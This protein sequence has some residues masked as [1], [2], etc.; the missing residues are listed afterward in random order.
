MEM[1][2]KNLK[3]Y[4][5]KSLLMKN[6]KSYKY[7]LS[8]IFIFSS[9]YGVYAYSPIQN[10]SWL[11]KCY[12]KID[13]TTYNWTVYSKWWNEISCNWSLNFSSLPNSIWD[14][15]DW[16]YYL[17]LKWD[18]STILWEDKSYSDWTN[19]SKSN[20][21]WIKE[22]WPYKID[23]KAPTCTLKELKFISWKSNNQYY[24]NWKL[25]YKGN[26]WA[27]EFDL[28]IESND[29]WS[30]SNTSEIKEIKFPTILWATPSIQSFTNSWKVI[31][32]WKYSWS[33][34]QNDTFDILNNNVDVCFDN[35]WNNSKLSKDSSTKITFENWNSIVWINNLKLTP[36]N[37]VPNIAW[38]NYDLMI[39]WIK[40]KSWNDWNWS[41]ISVYDWDSLNSKYFSA[42]H[43]RELIIP[44]FQDNLSWLKSF[45]VNIEKAYDKNS[46]S[47]YI[48]SLS[49]SDS[50]V[51]N[52]SNLSLIHDF[53][54]IDLDINSNWYRPYSWDIQTLNLSWNPVETDKIC[55]MVWNC[56]STPTPDFKLVAN[57]PILAQ[58]LNLTS[59]YNWIKHNLN[60]IYEW[61]ISNLYDDYN[62]VVNFEDIYWNAIVAVSWVKKIKLNSSF[63]NT[64]WCNQYNSPNDWDC[65]DFAFRNQIDNNLIT[66]Y[67]HDVAAEKHI[68]NYIIDQY[69]QFK[70][71][72]NIEI[73]S[74]IPTKNEYLTLWWDKLYWNLSAK[75]KLN[76]L[77]IKVDNLTNY[78][79]IW[80]NP[81]SLELA[82]VWNQA[83]YKW[84]PIIN[85]N[86][87]DNIYPLVEGQEKPINISNLVN[88]D[89][90]LSWYKLETKLWTNNMFM[91]FNNIYLLWWNVYTWWI[92]PEWHDTYDIIKNIYS[93]IYWY[94]Y[95]PYS[96]NDD[97]IFTPKTVWW[98]TSSNTNLAFYSK[99]NYRV[100]N[101]TKEAIIPSIQTWFSSFWIHS[102]SDFSD[103]SLY[104]S[105]S[106]IIFAELDIR[107]I[108]QT[109]NSTLWTSNWAWAVNTD[110]SF[111][112]FSSISL[113]DVKTEIKKNVVSLL[114]W[115]D[116]SKWKVA[117]WYTLNNLTI[118]PSDK[119]LS[120]QNWN[121]LYFKD[122][123]IEINCSWVCEIN[124][125]K[126]IIVENGN[127]FLNSDMKY[128]NKD[129]I[130]WFILV[131]NSSNWNKSQFRIAE[132]ITNWVWII[133]SD[134]PI[135]SVKN[136]NSKVYDWSNITNTSLWNQL[137]WKWSF[138]TRNTVWW[139]IKNN[140]WNCPYWTPEYQSSACTVEKAQ[141]YDLIYLRRYWRIDKSYYW[142]TNSP[143]WD[144][145]VPLNL[146]K[147]N[148]QTAWGDS[149]SKI[150]WWISTKTNWNLE[151]P[152]NYNPN[153]P[154]IIE[155]DS[156][157]QTNPPIWFTK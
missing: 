53:S 129:S 62:S 8:L 69:S 46:F 79:G 13:W 27:W 32:T 9:V 140:T 91:Q 123:D 10:M 61:N 48:R 58:N 47:W 80:E 151:K 127:I 16:T 51:T 85:Y 82:T 99:L 87:I 22:F 105:N 145:K 104:N 143:M 17:K 114:K 49:T 130:I 144:L 76:N 31:V 101:W 28:I 25:F 94:W 146:D 98:I 149:Y 36:D 11:N 125:K 95:L 70:W 64:L 39:N 111:K 110:N 121:I 34:N 119:W 128:S 142:V 102:P 131:W 24:N 90:H 108:S 77:N 122:T 93:S 52:L 5:K 135:V 150:S 43:D 126:T 89:S 153:S 117:W 60:S 154:L 30:G 72:L 103:S 68:F 33:W 115:Q 73:K 156:N 7:I 59:W 112:D 3:L 152:V 118:F 45:K 134:W 109:R 54:D 14:I 138:A 139:A 29:I 100:W 155:Y 55:D 96:W 157:L 42:L 2:L 50:L 26:S 35:A 75:L 137:Y 136:D 1:L 20:K 132:K 56:I 71:I 92:I 65:I 44:A 88:W 66:W 12:Y 37:N 81:S 19:T 107:W 97:F 113:F 106:S 15:P 67:T 84:N 78:W 57:S 38:T 63:D 41:N 86:K 40:F 74:A 21:Y 6:N 147:I 23:T 120:L 124:W 4:I 133:Y 18:D 148:I 83:E 141:S 116:S